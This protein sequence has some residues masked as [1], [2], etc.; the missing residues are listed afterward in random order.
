MPATQEP[1]E[2][3]SMATGGPMLSA[4]MQILTTTDLGLGVRLLSGAPTFQHLGRLSYSVLAARAAALAQPRAGVC[5]ARNSLTR[6]LA[7]VSAAPVFHSGMNSQF[8]S[9]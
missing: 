7:A 8:G 9:S 3:R 6:A 5:F 2:R 1:A 4:V